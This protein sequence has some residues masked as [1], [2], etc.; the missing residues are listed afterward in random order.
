MVKRNE[1]KKQGRILVRQN[2][3]RAI[4]VCFLIA[5]LTTA[6]PVT[7]T[8]F[9]FHSV[10]GLPDGKAVT[11]DLSNSDVAVQVIERFFSWRKYQ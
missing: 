9:G 2:Y 11:T 5:M 4:S 7:T 3:L 6:Y 8:F 1:L 10:S